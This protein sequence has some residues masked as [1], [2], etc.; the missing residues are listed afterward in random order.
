MLS[1]NQ[2]KHLTNLQLVKHRR[3]HGQFV[4]EGDKMVAELLQQQRIAVVSVFALEG[5]AKAHAPLLVPYQHCLTL[6]D[7]EALQKVSSLHTSNQVLAVARLPE[8]P[9]R[10]APIGQGYSFYL[11]GLQD[12]GNVGTILRT[13]DWFGFSAVVCSPDTAD[14]YSPKVVQASMGALWRVPV[15]T[16]RMAEV[17]DSYP[18]VARIGAVMDGADAFKASF[19]AKGILVIGNEGKGIRPDILPLLT[20]RLTIPKGPGSGAESLN[21]AVAAGLLAGLARCS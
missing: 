12:P 15:C 3:E 7:A 13:A 16:A 5:W 17:A 1:H 8:V 18:D 2:R 20:H 11:D 21:A 19:P 10:T 6:I 4:V 9:F 14:V